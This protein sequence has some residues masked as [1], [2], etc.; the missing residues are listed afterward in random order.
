MV[1]IAQA[2]QTLE[3]QQKSAQEARQKL[4]EAR[5]KLPTITQ[6]ELRAGGYAGMTGAL[7]R[8]QVER[9]KKEIEARQKVISGYTEKLSEYEKTIKQ[10][11]A[12]KV[13]YGK[14]QAAIKQAY[15]LYERGIS[16]YWIKGEPSYKYLKELEKQK[17][18]TKQLALKKYTPELTSFG[19]SGIDI[20][21]LDISKLPIIPPER[22]ASLR[23]GAPGI[24]VSKFPPIKGLFGERIDISKYPGLDISKLDVS[25]IDVSRFPTISQEELTRLG[26]DVGA[27]ISVETLM[28]EMPP[29]SPEQAI[30]EIGVGSIIKGLEYVGKVGEIPIVVPEPGL[31]P[32]GLPPSI[33]LSTIG[34]EARRAREAITE[35]GRLVEL[36]WEE[37]IGKERLIKTVPEK[38]IPRY[39]GE[40][41]IIDIM[42]GEIRPPRELVI[43]EHEEITTLGL[44]PKAARV[45]PEVLAYTLA[46]VPTLTADVLAAAEKMK[47]IEKDV[48]IETEKQ[49]KEHLKEELPEGYRYLTMEE[50]EIEVAPEIETKMKE[51]L[52]LE[53][54]VSLAFLGGLAAFRGVRAITKPIITTK[55][56]KPVQWFKEK[57]FVT[58]KGRITTFDVYKYRAP[59]E[60]KITTPFREWFGIKPKVDWA[61]ITKPQL[62]VFRPFAGSYVLGRAPYVAE[63]G[64]VSKVPFG[65]TSKAE[66]EALAR[67]RARGRLKLFEIRGKAEPITPEEIIKL[68]KPEKYV[69]T[70]KP[71][72]IVTEKGE[73]LTQALIDSYKYFGRPGRTTQAFYVGA[74]VK[75]RVKIG[76][77]KIFEAR[78][79][80]KE[81]TK[82]F[83]RAAGK[84]PELRGT[85][86][87]IPL[88]EPPPLWTFDISKVKFKPP[89]PRMPP[90]TLK[91]PPT[92][93]FQWLEQLP[94]PELMVPPPPTEMLKPIT[95]V[96]KDLPAVKLLGVEKPLMVGGMGITEAKYAGLGLYER[97]ED[98]PVFKEEVVLKPALVEVP[99]LRIIPKLRIIPRA[100]ERVEVIPKETLELREK[101]IPKLKI[102]S[103]LRIIQKV[104]VVPKVV[105]KVAVRPRPRPGKPRPPKIIPKIPFYLKRKEEK[106]RELKKRKEELVIP[107]VRRYRKW[108]KIGKPMLKRE[109]IIKGV[110]ELRRTLAASLQLRRPSGAVVPFAKPTKEFRIGKKGPE[111]LVQRAPRRLKAPTEVQEII[112]ARKAGRIKFLK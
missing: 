28:K 62:E 29:I 53:A 106:R 69:W 8:S 23:L 68:P 94:K 45:A 47:T 20:S 32:T 101:I 6:R 104:K 88:K 103:K 34:A 90:P 64:K 54:G 60:V 79:G 87:E 24:D 95:K 102:I 2:R 17:S 9:A 97:T 52:A 50:F 37:I 44:I 100:V 35:T 19:L 41:G 42:T 111:I 109:A 27:P 105:P 98:V 92:R 40:T 93:P 66:L 77:I 83:Y 107:F 108:I 31:I 1:T 85:L 70:G 3:Q 30:K 72:I 48:K 36:G 14:K 51:Q 56:P 84:I 63:L 86:I 49:Y 16:S 80:F 81:V 11:E 18:L 10:A 55:I 71:G 74:R 96:V 43:P 75:P 38:V 25:K 73:K 26:F 58:P 89:L 99:R 7:R 12:Q 110:A 82:P 5:K 67:I 22:L 76:D 91:A 59:A 21:K 112:A 15:K 78:M 65:I 33:R 46:P 39:E 57:A 4:A 13:A 61:P